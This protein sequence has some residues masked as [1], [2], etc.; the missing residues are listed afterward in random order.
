MVIVHSYVSLPEGTQ[1]IIGLIIYAT[2]RLYIYIYI[3]GICIH[4]Y[5]Y[6]RIFMCVCAFLFL[7]TSDY[8]C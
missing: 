5:I 1:Y 4:I 6:V 3:L 7:V 2:N 8:E